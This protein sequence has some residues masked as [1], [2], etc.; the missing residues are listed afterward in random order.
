[1]DPTEQRRLLDT[2]L[3]AAAAEDCLVAP[4]GSVYFLFHDA[5]RPSTKDVDAV[6]HTASLKVAPLDVLKRVAGKLGKV[7]VTTDEAVAWV[8]L[9]SGEKIE[10]IRG[11]SAAKGGFF[12][13][14]LL[15]EAAASAERR[16]NLLLYPMEY[17]IL[18]KADA[19]VDREERAGRD[20][21][22]AEEHRRRAAGFRAD[23]FSEVNRAMLG[24]GLDAAKL[25][26]GIGCLKRKRQGEVTALLQGAGAL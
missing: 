10:L 14:E 12:P 13:R 26:S 24:P 16:G 11:R 18:L 15:E 20:P 5:A 23:V 9:E 1:M 4:V 7:E 19:A 17:V 3:A 8:R 2:V 22:R 21:A 25:R 6:I